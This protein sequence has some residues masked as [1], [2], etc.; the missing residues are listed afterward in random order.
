MKDAGIHARHALAKFP[1]TAIGTGNVG[2]LHVTLDRRFYT[3]E[4]IARLFS[5]AMK[6][7]VTLTITATVMF[8]PPQS[9]ALALTTSPSSLSFSGIQGGVTP[10]AQAITFWKGNDRTRTWTATSGSAWMTVSPSSGTIST[11]RDQLTASVDLT[12]LS[13]GN[14]STNIVIAITGLKGHRNL[15]LIPV[16]LTITGTTSAT[17]S[18]S[19]TPTALSFSGI[20]GGIAP[21]AQSMSLRNPTGGTLSWSMS[22]NAAWLSLAPASGTTTTESDSISAGV[23]LTGLAAGTYTAAITI[24]ATGATNTPQVIPVSLTVSPA[25]TASPVIGLSVSNMAFTGT[26]GGSNPATQSLTISNTGTGTLSWTVGDNAA[27]LTL[28]PTS[29]T[30][31]GTVSASASL[32]GLAAGTY[33][34]TITVSATGAT[35][36]TIQVTLT[37]SSTTSTNGSAILS[38]TANTESDLAGYKVYRGTQSGVYGTSIAVGNVTTYQFTNLAPNT[39]YFFSITA[40]DTAG[41]ESVPSSEVSK[42]VY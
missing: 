27:W 12:G 26:A 32:S 35:S 39:T 1:S 16:T 8:L 19:L 25:P 18:I 37:V 2:R 22:S 29:G 10:P 20:A 31:A 24:S 42:S 13:A 38:W 17:P 7:L 11:E 21:A 14:Y 4:C 33:S 5:H 30:N 23:N 15:T 40:L 9:Q 3:S 6:C 41:N 36:K 28:S 34:G